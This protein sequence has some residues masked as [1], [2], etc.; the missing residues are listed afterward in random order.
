MDPPAARPIDIPEILSA[1]L[2]AAADRPEYIEH[3]IP[4]SERIRASARLLCKYALVSKLWNDCATP[5]LWEMLPDQLALLKLLPDDAWTMIDGDSP[6]QASLTSSLL[7]GAENRKFDMAREF[8]QDD[9]KGIQR[10]GRHVRILRHDDHLCTPTVHR[11]ILTAS[12]LLMCKLER[13]HVTMHGSVE[14]F[15]LYSSTIWDL[16]I[17][18]RGADVPILTDVICPKLTHLLLDLPLHRFDNNFT[19]AQQLGL[20]LIGLSSVTHLSVLVGLDLAGILV[21]LLGQSVSVTHL[22]LM[23]PTYA[24]KDP[25]SALAMQHIGKT[26]FKNLRRL[27]LPRVCP[28]FAMALLQYLGDTPREIEMLKMPITRFATRD[29]MK[30]LIVAVAEHCSPTTLTHL[31]IL[32]GVPP[33]PMFNDPPTPLLVPLDFLRP[34]S[35]HRLLE[36]ISI[37]ETE[38]A[39]GLTDDAYSELAQWWPNLVRLRVPNATG[40]SCTLRTLL[41]FATHCKQLRTLTLKLDV[42]SAYLPNEEVA[43]AKTPAPALERLE[44]NDGRIVVADEV[45]DCLTALFPALTEVAYRADEE[46]MFYDEAAVIYREEAW[47]RVSRM[48]RWYR[49][50]KSGPW[51]DFEDF[52]D[53][54]DHQYASSRGMPFF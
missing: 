25:S 36:E 15:Q 46:L 2:E 11:L 13:L 24:L 41:A 18:V 44:I 22:R 5:W 21:M 53:A 28:E 47:D 51:T 26:G 39:V 9:L 23:D 42:R 37:G 12:S 43:V 54:V 3:C 31:D 32:A 35:Q 50:V 48:L 1:I 34:L 16:Q 14:A 30:T 38:G 19:E 29:E 10:L 52:E 20:H 17:W 8:N 4:T 45:A 33:T 40:T 7:T 49:S 6:S 27:Q